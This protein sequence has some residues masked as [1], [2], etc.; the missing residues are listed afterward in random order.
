MQTGEIEAN[1]SRLNEGFKLHYLDELIERKIT[2]KEQETIPA[3]DI[4]FFQ[5][6]YERLISL[7]EEVSQT[8]T[9]PEIPQGKAALNDLLVRL[10]LNPL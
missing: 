5:R 7:L 10:R 2:G 3:T 6:E 1:L 8:T 4:D 9:L